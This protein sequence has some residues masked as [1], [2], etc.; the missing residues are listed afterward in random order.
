MDLQTAR[1]IWTDTYTCDEL[2]PPLTRL[3]AVAVLDRNGGPQAGPSEIVFLRRLAAQYKR[4][5]LISPAGDVDYRAAEAAGYGRPPMTRDLAEK[6]FSG[7]FSQ[8]PSRR[9]YI[10]AIAL[11][12]RTGGPLEGQRYF[13]PIVSYYI[14]IGLISPA[15]EVNYPAIVADEE[16]GLK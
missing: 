15:G 12:H 4:D 8:Y 7:R 11:L 16:E 13:V 14:G 9:Q 10:E 2:H 3:E 5:G 6:I 1:T